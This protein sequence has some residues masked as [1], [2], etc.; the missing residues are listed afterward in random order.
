MH[1]GA[2]ESVNQVSMVSKCIFPL[3]AISLSIPLEPFLSIPLGWV[4]SS[5][6]LSV[7][8]RILLQYFSE[9]S[10]FP[11]VQIFFLSPPPSSRF[12]ASCTQSTAASHGVW[13]T[14]YSL[15]LRFAIIICRALLL[16][17]VIGCDK[18][19][20]VQTAWIFCTW[21]TSNPAI[22]SR[23]PF[24]WRSS[25]TTKAWNENRDVCLWGVI[26]HFATPLVEI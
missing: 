11:W 8:S 7:L 5:N 23:F 12:K 25:K 2:G 4:L 16:S 26:W 13:S 14:T 15:I 3:S 1:I 21:D 19:F 6:P 18:K 9:F 22:T 24:I 20:N 17:F 10:S